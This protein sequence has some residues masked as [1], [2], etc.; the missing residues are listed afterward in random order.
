MHGKA[1]R[2][3][4]TEYMHF[5]FFLLFRSIKAVDFTTCFSDVNKVPIKYFWKNGRS[6]KFTN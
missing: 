6:V 2:L 3:N 5:F 1:L 4:D